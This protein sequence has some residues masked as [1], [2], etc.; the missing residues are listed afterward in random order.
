VLRAIAVHPDVQPDGV[1]LAAP[2]DRLLTTVEH[3][4]TTMG[5][6]SFPFARLLVFWGGV[7]QH[8]SPFQMDPI[9][10]AASARCPALFLQGGEDPWVRQSEG[11]AVFRSLASAQKKLVIFDRA[12]H[13]P[14][15]GAD[16]GRWKQSVQEYLQSLQR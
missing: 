1:I 13:E 5:L 14:L 11:E 2:Y 12:S 7:G 15:S 9:R 6:P 8:F 10:Y 4:F 16:P 3:R